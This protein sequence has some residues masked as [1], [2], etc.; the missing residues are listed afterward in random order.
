MEIPAPT[1]G[2]SPAVQVSGGKKVFGAINAAASIAKQTTI[3]DQGQ[4]YATS[5]AS[6]PA[7]F[8][9]IVLARRTGNFHQQLNRDQ[10]A[11]I[12]HV[13]DRENHAGD[14]CRPA[15]LAPHPMDRRRA[16][17][18]AGRNLARLFLLSLIHI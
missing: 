7:L 9:P 12:D 8:L 11:G 6:R 18:G 1:T 2:S 3:E 17:I 15:E 4:L 16:G 5:R 13:E 10:P 14:Q